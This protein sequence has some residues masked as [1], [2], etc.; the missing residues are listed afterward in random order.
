MAGVVFKSVRHT[1][2]PVQGHDAR[3]SAGSGFPWTRVNNCTQPA[4][5][6]FAADVSFEPKTSP[7]PV[8]FKPDQA[9]QI[10]HAWLA[11]G[12]CPWPRP[13]VDDMPAWLGPAMTADE[14]RRALAA[15]DAIKACPW[16][17][18]V[19]LPDKSPRQGTPRQVADWRAGRL[20]V[21]ELPIDTKPTK[22]N[23]P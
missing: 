3:A 13:V 18:M 6:D 17:R 2:T 7:A 22:G 12:A 5:P 23:A 20:D 21:T 9:V 4:G 14:Q 19:P 16:P 8:M 1:W 10:D 11:L 15:W